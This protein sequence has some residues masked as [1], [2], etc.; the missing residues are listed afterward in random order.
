MI[1]IVCE[2]EVV[3]DEKVTFRWRHGGSVFTTPYDLTNDGYRNFDN[4]AGQARKKLEKLVG[5][6]LQLS[7]L[8][9]PES[10]PPPAIEAEQQRL[11]RLVRQD[12]FALAEIG[13]N[14]YKQVFLL[15]ECGDV[16]QGQAQEVVQW[17]QELRAAKEEVFLELVLDG[18]CRVPWNV[19]YEE[20]P[21]DHAAA[22]CDDS[23]AR[24]RWEPF[25][26]VR[27]C[28]GGGR[29]FSPMF[30]VPIEENPRVLLVIDRSV[31]KRLPEAQQQAFHNFLRQHRLP[32]PV[33]RWDALVAALKDQPPHLIY[34]LSH[35]TSAA[36]LKLD[37][38][39][40]APQD[41]KA[42]LSGADRP[43]SGDRRPRGGLAF[44]N[45]CRTG[46]V[47]EGPSFLEAL[48]KVG[49]S[50]L[51]VT[52]VETVDAF[53]GPF[54]LEFLKGFLVD[55]LPI[56]LLLRTIRSNGVPLG[57]LYFAHCPPDYHVRKPTAPPGPQDAVPPRAVKSAPLDAGRAL[58]GTADAKVPP[59][60]LPPKPYPSLAYYDSAYR[61]L[62]AGREG[63]VQLFTDLLGA[64]DTRL[65]VLHGQSG[66]GKSSFLLAGVIPYLEVGG[67]RL[68]EVPPPEDPTNEEA[69]VEERNVLFVRATSDL[70]GQVAERLAKYC[71]RPTA[72]D[73]P[74]RKTVP[75]DLP[76]LLVGQLRQ[77]PLPERLTGD[78]QRDGEAGAAPLADALRLALGKELSED[79]ALLGR[80]LA[81]LGDALPYGLVLVIDQGEEIFTLVPT[82][83]EDQDSRAALEA[84][85]QNDQVR[86]VALEMLRRAAPARG[87]FKIIVSL[88]TEYCGRL[89]AWL[90]W[91]W[92]DSTR[93]REYLLAPLS[94]GQLAEAIKRPTSAT[95][96]PHTSKA[97]YEKYNFQY[98]PEVA[99]E[100]ARRLVVFS[101]EGQGGV[102]PLAQMICTQLYE[103]VSRRSDRVIRMEDFEQI[104]GVGGG[105][106]RHVKTLLSRILTDP[107]DR[108]AFERLFRRLYRRQPDGSLTTALVP[109]DELIQKWKRYGARTPLSQVLAL[110]SKGEW[111]L[112]RV[113]ALRLGG[114]DVRNY[115]SLGHDALAP[116]AAAWDEEW[117]RRTRLRKKI[118]AVLLA[119]FLPVLAILVPLLAILA[120]IAWDRAKDADEAKGEALKA[121]KRAHRYW[122]VADLN[123]V[124][125][126]W[127]Q[128]NIE[129]MRLLLRRH[130]PQNSQTADLR[131]FEWYYWWQLCSRAREHPV[132][133][134]ALAY[135]LD[136]KTLAAAS[137]ASSAYQEKLAVQFWDV[138]T[139]RLRATGMENWEGG[140]SLVF[141]PDVKTL[142]SWSETGVVR[143]WDVAKG[144]QRVELPE[145]LGS[146]S[147]AVSPDGTT[148]AVGTM[149][150]STYLYDVA[151][152][153][154]KAHLGQR[155]S[156]KAVAFSPDGKTL[157][158]ASNMVC[159]WNVATGKLRTDL[160]GATGWITSLAF[161]P[162]G[163][164][165]AAGTESGT[166]HLWNVATGKEPATLT[167]H[168]EAVTSVAFSR[169]GTTLVSGSNDRTVRL[170]DVATGEA[171]M[172]FTGHK[173]AVTSVA[174]SPDGASVASASNDRTI[175]LWDVPSSL[176]GHKGAVSTVAFSPLD[177][178]TLA[179]GGHDGLV[180]LWDLAA[181][182][183]RPLL[184][185][186]WGPVYRV[187]FSPSG[188]TLASGSEDGSIRLWDVAAGQVRATLRGHVGEVHFAFSPDGNTLASAGA[189]GKV[190]LWDVAA[191]KE[192]K[193]L[194]GH[195]DRVFGVAYSPNGNT[196]AS[197]GQD[198]VVR[199]WDM[200]S[201]TE[202]DPLGRHNGP[203]YAV[204][205]SPDGKTLAW[206]GEEGYQRGE[207]R[208][209]D[210]DAGTELAKLK[211]HRG[212]V[213]SVAYSPDGK[214]LASGSGDGSVK[215]WDVD[216]AQELAT[217]QT[218][219][220]LGGNMGIVS[221]AF[222]AD[223]KTLAGG[224]GEGS[225]LLW[226]AATEEQVRARSAPK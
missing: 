221:V 118:G 82:P 225:V 151:S 19:V 164:T 203:I 210:V 46:D 11:Q 61:A 201:Y 129:H 160:P 195:A 44:L 78:L 26:G 159:L 208:L 67:Y 57:L 142:V 32:E 93:V 68:L 153:K 226:R 89:M 58:G 166:V 33:E 186:D 200:D 206:A 31:F 34:W 219:L 180:W 204:A 196:L 75:I 172:V 130:Q 215:L 205:F 56:G 74:K 53:A 173:E 47:R 27:Y 17:L 188:N 37:D 86:E 149:T 14:L 104:G 182:K 122:Y 189:D 175:R 30:R 73:T 185:G 77:D 194:T 83:K 50:G 161:S 202:R 115:V 119:V 103:I 111:R 143:L 101:S 211:G 120:I 16:H 170:W 167:G 154:Q 29:R 217:L 133:V 124:Q 10:R 223:G 69:R 112:L 156:I 165:L 1:H 4:L 65:L 6:W 96:I 147:V 212:M 193:V 39:K 105:M 63:D 108:E 106:E 209:W 9:P 126:D 81:A 116:I 145:S 107:A 163:T 220:Q 72:Y 137:G 174:V 139:G 214:T 152:G 114:Q 171:R 20:E 192:R 127:K 60:L 85:R 84:L 113:N 38:R 183:E 110:A 62:F 41:L 3:L 117:E 158:S 198:G 146:A 131:G 54:G 141:S 13:H 23:L 55:R 222:A 178:K 181:G 80:V 43:A 184:R 15:E 128:G 179:S 98:A 207:V 51:V 125:S 148:L 79:P 22:F 140:S 168:K 150:K 25:W 40:V 71:A 70:P 187:A 91:N 169:D 64:P 49:L 8:A 59:P 87:N 100:I 144:T 109:E 99:E 135:S 177:G 134:G 42:L 157:A 52:E 197:V 24:T 94:E 76:R 28:L 18:K 155:G 21:A 90:R 45:A 224:N 95:E 92:Q 123:V 12:S 190:R 218:D 36:S 136:G 66:V 132:P 138:D 97:P 2:V 162:R 216:T 48:Y 88:R 5:D 7:N 191:G 213:S 176:Q 35:A 102:L 199:R 121:E